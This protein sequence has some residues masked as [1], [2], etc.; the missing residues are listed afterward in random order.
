MREGFAQQRCPKLA[1]TSKYWLLT[2]SAISRL[3]RDTYYAAKIRSPPNPTRTRAFV[4]T[5]ASRVSRVVTHLHSRLP[6]ATEASSCVRTYFR[7]PRVIP[8]TTAKL[9]MQQHAKTYRIRNMAALCA[10]RWNAEC[11]EWWSL[12]KS[13]LKSRCHQLRGVEERL[14]VPGFCFCPA[15]AAACDNR[16]SRLKHIIDRHIP[17]HKGC[18]IAVASTLLSPSSERQPDPV[19]GMAPVACRSCSDGE[20][21]KKIWNI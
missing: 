4:N 1:S 21:E 16:L 17:L 10:S 14:A 19:G 11:S 9:S 20:K 3:H 18:H 6:S 5:Y 13:G 8:L 15:M 7:A 2:G 12:L